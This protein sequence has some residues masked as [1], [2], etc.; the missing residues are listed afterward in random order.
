MGQD[1]TMPAWFN[2]YL[3]FTL[4]L[5][6]HFGPHDPV[7]DAMTALENLRFRDS[8]RAIRYMV[9]FNK[10]ARRTGWNEQALARQYYRGLPDRLKDEIS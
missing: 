5:Q 7:T 10:H 4:E 1:G 2:N 8:S 3:L 6:R 9:D